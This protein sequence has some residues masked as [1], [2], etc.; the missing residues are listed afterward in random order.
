MNALPIHTVRPNEERF[1]N[2]NG[3]AM[4]LGNLGALDPSYPGAGLNAGGRRD[5]EVWQRYAEDT[6]TSTQ[7]AVSIRTGTTTNGEAGFPLAPEEGEDEVIEGK[8]LFRR[9]RS[10]SGTRRSPGARRRRSSEP[11]GGWRVKCVASTSRRSSA[12]SGR[13]SSSATTRFRCRAARRRR[14]SCGTSRSSARTATGCCIV[15]SRGLPSRNF[16]LWCGSGHRSHGGRHSRTPARACRSCG[17]T[18]TPVRTS[19]AAAD[20][21]T[22][23]RASAGPSCTAYR[24]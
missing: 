23:Q 1:R 22:V 11:R 13:T 6:A 4:K 18:A 3:V 5:A 19:R 8:L 9:H 2:P 10:G 7:L 16:E 12:T 24:V 21:A 17:P 15:A 20:T 14:R